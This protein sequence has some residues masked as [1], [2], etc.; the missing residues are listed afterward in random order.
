MRAAPRVVTEESGKKYQVGGSLALEK[1]PKEN[2]EMYLSSRNM[3][4]RRGW[5][6][7]LSLTKESITF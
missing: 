2:R 3:L 5:R 7:P 1:K 4:R 6:C